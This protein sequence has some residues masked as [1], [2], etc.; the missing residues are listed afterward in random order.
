MYV[1]YCTVT[2]VLRLLII[3]EMFVCI[4]GFSYGMQKY[5]NYS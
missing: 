1:L 3:V 5:L 4:Y 2:V